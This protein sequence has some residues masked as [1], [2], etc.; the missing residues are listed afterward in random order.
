MLLNKYLS[1]SLELFLKSNNSLFNL[2]I[3]SDDDLNDD[4]S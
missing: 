4:C 1:N 3:K 2:F